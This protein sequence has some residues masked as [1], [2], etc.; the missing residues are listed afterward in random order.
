M[1]KPIIAIPVNRYELFGL[2]NFPEVSVGM[3]LA[4]AIIESAKTEGGLNNKDILV[5]ASKIISKTEGCYK[6]TADVLP[7][8]EAKK[9]SEQTGKPEKICQII[10]D[11]SQQY[12]TNGSALLARTKHGFE[13]SSAGVD[14]ISDDE[15]ILLPE[16][17]DGSAKEISLALHK[18][19]G[20]DIAIIISDSHGR[21]D[22]AGAGAVALGCYGITP[23]RVSTVFMPGGKKKHTDE[24]LCDLFA[25]SAAVI[26]GQRGRGIP[27]V[28]IRG[29]DFDFD[30]K[31]TVRS[32]L[33][34]APK[35]SV[36]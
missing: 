35:T 17:P 26:M 20:L 5:I 14:R 13:L 15:V 10:I 18:K 24:T 11:Q 9:L 1:D 25:S 31:A 12:W 2:Q 19:L 28:C 34:H 3:N 36:E 30:T 16:N 22:R 7:S 33:H 23:L 32:I 27:A 29:I 4:K 6:S 8:E 21:A